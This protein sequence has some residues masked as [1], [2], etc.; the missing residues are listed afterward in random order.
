MLRFRLLVR[1][2]LFV[3]FE[4]KRIGM[5]RVNF[6]KKDV[7]KGDSFTVVTTVDYATVDGGLTDVT[8][9]HKVSKNGDHFH[10]T[11]STWYGL[12]SVGVAAIKDSL[13][14][15]GLAAGTSHHA[16]FQALVNEWKKITKFLTHL[17][18]AGDASVKS[19]GLD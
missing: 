7:A 11:T 18:A 13:A 6:N 4:R 14:Q 12:G 1:Y 16:G 3:L 17:N 10:D 2:L 15:A 8:L 9:T 5:T 19:M